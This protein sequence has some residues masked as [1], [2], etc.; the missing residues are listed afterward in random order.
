MKVFKL[1]FVAFLAFLCFGLVS[2]V[3]SVGALEDE[4][5]EKESEDV[6]SVCYHENLISLERKEPSCTE[7]GCEAGIKCLSC[8]VVIE[9]LKPIPATGHDVYVDS[10]IPVTSCISSGLTAGEHCL[11]CGAVLVA[12]EVIPPLDHD[13]TE[14][15]VCRVCQKEAP[16]STFSVG[17]KSYSFRSGMSWTVW[18]SSAYNVDN[19]FIQD[20]M[21]YVS[22]NSYISGYLDLSGAIEARTYSTL[23]S[24]G[25]AATPI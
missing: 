13:Y 24:S 22:S 10:A 4:T 6:S 3:M 20:D 8:G 9:G 14:N 23:S 15:G 7:E 1:V 25:G 2:K 17:G 12:Q 5:S 16:L 21:L 18:V 19:F 11:T